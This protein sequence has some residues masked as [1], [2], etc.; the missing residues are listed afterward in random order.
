MAEQDETVVTTL[1]RG[2]G[3]SG[4]AYA[5]VRYRS[6]RFGVTKDGVPVVATEDEGEAREAFAMMADLAKPRRPPGGGGPVG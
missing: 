3:L 1:A 4:R 2:T 5:L 6:G